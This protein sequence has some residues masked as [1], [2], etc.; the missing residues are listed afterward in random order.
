MPWEAI[1]RPLLLSK[2]PHPPPGRKA[3]GCEIRIARRS[4][5]G[6]GDTTGRTRTRSPRKLACK[7][8]GRNAKVLPANEEVAEYFRLLMKHYNNRAQ[9]YHSRRTFIAAEIADMRSKSLFLIGD[10]DPI[11]AFPAA[12]RAM[13]DFAIN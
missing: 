9:M 8:A 6:S 5:G 1:T 3:S 12:K 2:M 7:L 11:A 4:C 13:A 10:S